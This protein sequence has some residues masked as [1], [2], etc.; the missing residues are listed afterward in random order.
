MAVITATRFAPSHYV[1][2]T[3]RVELGQQFTAHGETFEVIGE[4]ITTG[5]RMVFARLREVGGRHDGNEFGGYLT[6]N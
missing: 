2:N 5:W 4:P 3:N 6:H 1:L